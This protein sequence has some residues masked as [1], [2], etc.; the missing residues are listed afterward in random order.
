MRVFFFFIDGIGLGDNNPQVNP[1]STDYTPVLEKLL[2]GRKLVRSSAPYHNLRASL[3]SVDACLGVSGVP[4]SATGQATLLTGENIAKQVGYHFGPWPNT[5]IVES[6]ENGNLFSSVINAGFRAGFLSAYP[7]SYFKGIQSGKRIYSVIPQAAVSAGLRLKNEQD[8]RQGM[9][10]SADITGEGWRD[11][12]H[13]LDTPI[14]SPHTAGRRLA[15][16]AM[17][18]EFSLF[19]YWLSDYAGHEQD[20]T[21]ATHILSTLD[22]VLD[23]LLAGWDDQSGLILV[24]SDH[25]N[26]EDLST[27]RHTLNPV[28]VLA[29]GAPHLRRLFLKNLNSITDIHPLILQTLH[30]EKDTTEGANQDVRR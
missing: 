19:E 26:M 27:R 21:K 5:A 20:M 18:Y 13:L 8:L 11:R 4:Q 24:T 3:F 7:P 6:L 29:I 22:Q 9:A 15:E 17:D 16:L 14:I 1:F 30:I 2:G 23:G 10:I 25:G 28:P 12:L